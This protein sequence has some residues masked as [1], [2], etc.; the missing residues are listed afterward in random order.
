MG[1]VDE[2][3]RQEGMQQRLD[4]R[5]GRHRID[6]VRALDAHHVLVG[7]RR[8]RAQLAQRRRA[9]PPAGPPARSRAMSQPEPLTHSTSTSSPSRSGM[10]GLHRGVAAAV[11]HELR[12][13]AEQPRRVDAQ[14][15]VAADAVARRSDRPSPARRDRPSRSSSARSC[16][17]LPGAGQRPGARSRARPQ[18]RSAL[19][20][21]ALAPPADRRGDRCSRSVGGLVTHRRCR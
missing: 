15:Q 2:L 10:R 17:R 19:A 18:T 6:Q 9:A 11:Q 21:H 8:A 12:I 14:R 3:V 1:V 4:R 5:I 20:E 13:A 7:E 16:A